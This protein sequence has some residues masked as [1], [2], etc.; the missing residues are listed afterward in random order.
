MPDP[1]IRDD[2]EPIEDQV[3]GHEQD[4]IH[5]IPSCPEPE[6]GGHSHEVDQQEGPD[7]GEAHLETMDNGETIA[8]VDD[9]P[10]EPVPGITGPRPRILRQHNRKYDPDVYDLSTVGCRTRSRRSVRRAL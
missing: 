7:P 9:S 8:Q 1:E 2:Q 6:V 3:R 4:V 5:Q 10:S